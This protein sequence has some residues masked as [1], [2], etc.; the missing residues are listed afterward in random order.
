MPD[1]P[2]HSNSESKEAFRA[3]IVSTFM[4]AA[5]FP[6][7]TARMAMTIST[8]T[9][10]IPLSCWW[11]LIFIAWGTVDGDQVG[12]ESP[13][14]ARADCKAGSGWDTAGSGYKADWG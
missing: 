6:A 8:M 10:A 12:S 11:H 13:A 3:K 14:P 1:L 9:S 2:S 5:K 7:R 4:E